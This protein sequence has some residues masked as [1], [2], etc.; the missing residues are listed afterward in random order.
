M[1]AETGHNDRTIVVTGATSGIGLAAAMRLAGMGVR[2]I[3]VGRS[4]ERGEQALRQIMRAHPGAQAR[5]LTADLAS[6]R[7]VRRLAEQVHAAAAALSG[8]RLDALVNNAGA[9][10]SRRTLTE[11]GYEL[12]FAVNHLAPF[13]LTHTLL[14]LLQNTP[15]GRVITVSS[16]SHYHARMHWQDLTFRRGYF[17]LRAYRQSK[18]ANVLF[19]AELNRRL[20]GKSKVRAYAV[21][22]GLV[23]TGIGTKGTSA[24]V[25]WV[26]RQR[27]A[28]GRTPEQGA[29]TLVWLASQPQLSDPQA[30]YWKDCHPAAPSREALKPDQAAR[31]WALSEQMCG[32]SG[33]PDQSEP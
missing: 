29:E 27:A 30:L 6:Q 9:V 20:A 24:F 23:N 1:N 17:V 26:W 11:D 25:S 4:A 5:F 13:L 15:Q 14:P 19:S 33:A 28:S 16:T 18:L 22:P 2:L 3:G 10:A 7:Q 32:L 12:Q 31:L 8:G 21:D